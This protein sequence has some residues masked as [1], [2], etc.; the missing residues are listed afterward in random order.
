MSNLSQ[1]EGPEEEKEN[2]ATATLKHKHKAVMDEI[3]SVEEVCKSSVAVFDIL[4]GKK[5][6]PA[7]TTGEQQQASQQQ[8]QLLVSGEQGNVSTPDGPG[9]LGEI[10]LNKGQKE[11]GFEINAEDYLEIHIPTGRYTQDDLVW[12]E[13]ERL[14]KLFPC[15]KDKF[16][17]ALD[18][19]HAA[20]TEQERIIKVEKQKVR[21]NVE[22]H[23]TTRKIAALTRKKMKWTK[24]HKVATDFIHTRGFRVIQETGQVVTI[25]EQCREAGK[26]G[27]QSTKTMLAYNHVSK[28]DDVRNYQTMNIFGNKNAAM[29]ATAEMTGRSISRQPMKD[30]SAESHD[31]G[32]RRRRGGGFRGHGGSDRD[33]DGG[34]HG[35]GGGY[36]GDGDEGYGDGRG[37]QL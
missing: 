17:L 37:Q 23:L 5:R 12:T 6:S 19:I 16:Q 25:Q 32:G 8:Q 4:T 13:A 29:N 34:Y 33:H 28:V 15:T 3:K 36:G 11:D 7:K 22:G 30:D 18:E 9:V 2:T 31:D 1:E 14:D 24:E 27:Q 20:K 26:K 35:H 10:D 21:D